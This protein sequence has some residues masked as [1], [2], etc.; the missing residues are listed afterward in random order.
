MRGKSFSRRSADA[1]SWV[2]KLSLLVLIPSITFA[3]IAVVLQRRRW[4]VDELKFWF[5]V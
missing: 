3:L 1:D 5:R 2:I 4:I